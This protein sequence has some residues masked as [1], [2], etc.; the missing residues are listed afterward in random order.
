MVEEK[1]EEKKKNIKKYKEPEDIALAATEDF[2]FLHNGKIEQVEHD[3]DEGYQVNNYLNEP[4]TE[5]L[6]KL[7]KTNE[8]LKTLLED[9]GKLQ[10]KAQAASQPQ[11]KQPQP[12]QG[13]EESIEEIPKDKVQD[14]ITD[15]K[16]KERGVVV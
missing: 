15:R 3:M 6:D 8:K 2:S 4:T 12:C 9:V 7:K 13:C 16:T 10:Q 1:K 5:Q 11:P 14:Y